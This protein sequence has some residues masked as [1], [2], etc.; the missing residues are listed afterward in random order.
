MSWLTDDPTPI[1]I[2]GGT[3]LLVLLV[4]LL[5]TGRGV[6][7]LAMAGVVLCIVAAI[8][9]D[10][11]VVTDR[12]V[13][14]QTLLSAAAAAESN[15]LDAVEKFISPS[16]PHLNGQARSWISQIILESVSIN[17]IRIE[18]D[19]S[20]TP[21]VATA[22]FWYVAHGRLKRGDTVHE[23]VPGRLT[24][25]LQKEGDRWLVTDYQRH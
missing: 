2:A 17:G 15:N 4:F 14:E 10:A 24:V 18:I 9:I 3:A 7:L 5:K 8:A 12:E 19:D 6:I 22:N 25:K 16:V 1:F 23:R 13:V 21:P 11:M 20:K